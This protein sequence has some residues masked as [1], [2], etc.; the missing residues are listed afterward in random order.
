MDGDELKRLIR[1]GETLGVEFKGEQRRQFTS[2]Y[3]RL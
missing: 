3:E 2:L 1:G